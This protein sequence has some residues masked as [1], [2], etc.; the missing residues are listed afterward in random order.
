MYI[1]RS[2]AINSLSNEEREEQLV[3]LIFVGNRQLRVMPEPGREVSHHQASF[4]LHASDTCPL[5]YLSWEQ[6][7]A[8]TLEIDIACRVPQKGK[9]EL[10]LDPVKYIGSDKRAVVILIS[11]AYRRRMSRSNQSAPEGSLRSCPGDCV[12]RGPG[13]GEGNIPEGECDEIEMDDGDRD[14]DGNGSGDSEA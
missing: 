12:G 6:D 8:N 10:M 13:F 2:E 1:F 14:R 11:N 9:R 7:N 5:Y 4:Y 3:R